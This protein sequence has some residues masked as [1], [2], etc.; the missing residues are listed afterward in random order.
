MA[1]ADIEMSG[2]NTPSP[3]TCAPRRSPRVQEIWKDK[4][5][6]VDPPAS[7]VNIPLPAASAPRRSPRVQDLEK[8]KGKA[9]DY[10]TPTAASK[11]N[12]SKGKASAPGPMPSPRSPSP[13][14]DMTMLETIANNPHLDDPTTSV[15]LLAQIVLRCKEQRVWSARPT[16]ECYTFL[17]TDD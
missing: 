8:D 7:T 1:P 16:F 9:V 13:D 11:S 6:A 17:D 15:G 4:A 3:A 10:P 2:A 5:K 14:D 12:R